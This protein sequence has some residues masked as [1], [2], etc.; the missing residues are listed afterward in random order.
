MLI[1][2]TSIRSKLLR[3]NEG[4][5]LPGRED[6]APFCT[7]KDTLVG[8]GMS[9]MADATGR[10][11]TAGGVP[12][13]VPVPQWHFCFRGMAAVTLEQPHS[14]LW[15]W[16]HALNGLPG[17]LTGTINRSFACVHFVDRCPRMQ[18]SLTHL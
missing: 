15:R 17:F 8:E 9:G 13:D 6:K 4:F 16:G 10:G 1:F 2:S 3:S 14:W 5:R 7:R 11:W 18:G 12:L